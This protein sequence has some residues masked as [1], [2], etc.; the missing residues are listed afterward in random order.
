MTVDKMLNVLE[1]KGYSDYYIAKKTGM[2][3]ATICRIRNRVIVNSRIVTAEKIR[4][5]YE[6]ITGQKVDNFI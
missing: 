3:M 6:N 4:A 1:K 2:A 5:V